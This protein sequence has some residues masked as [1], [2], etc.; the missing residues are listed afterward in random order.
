MLARAR[1][2]PL[3]HL[4]KTERLQL[5]DRGRDRLAMDSVFF[6]LVVGDGQ[7]AVVVAAMLRKLDADAIEN[8]PSGQAQHAVCRAYHH[9]DQ[10]GIELPVYFVEFPAGQ[11]YS[12]AFL[13]AASRKAVTFS[14]VT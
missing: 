5:P 2:A 7:L 6:E 13:A 9:L 1:L 3:R 12:L 14:G 4:K 8:A 10:T 11:G